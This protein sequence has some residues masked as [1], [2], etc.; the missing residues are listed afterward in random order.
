MRRMILRS[1][2][3]RAAQRGVAAIEMAIMLLFL[4]PL[5][6]GITEVGR[7]FYQYDAITK[8]AS[9]G[10]RYL[11]T[12]APGDPNAIAAATCLVVYA[13]TGCTGNPVVPGLA[14]QLV[15]VCDRSS[16]AQ[17]NLLQTGFGVVNLVTVTVTGFQFVSD[18][19]GVAG[20]VTFGPIS[21]TFEQV[22]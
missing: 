19:P 4:I 3:E 18:V 7:A 12:Q 14:A 13:N 1:S 10:A 15:T 6:F 16:C 9:A 22:M 2:H 20:N 21:A 11:S 8:S 5:V 17:D